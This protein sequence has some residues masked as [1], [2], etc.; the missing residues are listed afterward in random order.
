M[1][2]VI[3]ITV[4]TGDVPRLPSEYV[5]HQALIWLLMVIVVSVIVTNL[6]T[7][8]IASNIGNSKNL[9]SNLNV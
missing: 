1:I 2:R 6:S 5:F 4:I 3:A 8:Y 9:F 7:S